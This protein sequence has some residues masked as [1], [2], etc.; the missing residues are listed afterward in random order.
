MILVSSQSMN[1]KNNH[2]FM[3]ISLLSLFSIGSFFISLKQ[4][5]ISANFSIY[6]QEPISTQQNLPISIDISISQLPYS[7]G[8]IPLIINCLIQSDLNYFYYC[9]DNSTLL[10]FGKTISTQTNLTYIQQCME[11]GFHLIRVMVLNESNYMLYNSSILF[12]ISNFPVTNNTPLSFFESLGAFN[13]ILWCLGVGSVIAIPARK[14]YDI[15]QKK[16]KQRSS[17][18]IGSISD[19]QIPHAQ[20]IYGIAGSPFY[21]LMNSNN[22]TSDQ[23]SC[24]LIN[25]ASIAEIRVYSKP[26]YNLRYKITPKQSLVN[27]FKPKHLNNTIRELISLPIDQLTP[28]ILNFHDFSVGLLKCEG[29]N[30]SI[31]IVIDP[32]TFNTS[33]EYFITFKQLLNSLENV[34][35][36]LEINTLFQ[37]YLNISIAYPIQTLNNTSKIQKFQENI[38]ADL[39]AF[40]NLSSKDTDEIMTDIQMLPLE[41]LNQI[42]NRM[43]GHNNPENADKEQESYE[44]NPSE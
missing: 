19:L 13:S 29:I 9:Y 40:D 10:G 14:I 44:Q 41:I 28:E 33:M 1:K 6:S 36:P 11:N 7:N 42:K 5:E 22:L 26:T 8:S 18:S 31:V 32:C 21:N 43:K 12:S 3:I 30:N 34:A 20:S 37:E 27:S 38:K 2:L 35:N 15:T 17:I 25:C 24:F 4:N 39:F 16:Q 23:K